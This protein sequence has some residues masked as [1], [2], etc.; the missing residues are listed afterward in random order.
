MIAKSDSIDKPSENEEGKYKTLEIGFINNQ[1]F[2][3][4]SDELKITGCSNEECKLKHFCSKF[5]DN[6]KLINKQLSLNEIKEI[7]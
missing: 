2:L 5:K 1:L 7:G 4:V 3:D 6:F